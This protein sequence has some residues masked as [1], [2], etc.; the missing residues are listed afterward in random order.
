MF[1]MLVILYLLLGGAGSGVCAVSAVLSLLCPKDAVCIVRSRPA[2]RV[3]GAA[4]PSPCVGWVV[5]PP[6]QYRR[7]MAPLF[8]ASLA[9]ITLGLACLAFD[10]GR[11][12]RVLLLFAS[13]TL[14]HITVGSWA[15]VLTAVLSA[16]L[17]CAWNAVALCLPLT[18]VRVAEV[19]A[20][21]SSLVS[22]AYTGLLLQGI[23]A[24]PLWGSLWLPVL[25]VLS[26][27][28]CGF[29][30]TIATMQLTGSTRVFG[31]VAR[32]VMAG[33]TAIIAVESVAAVLFA[34]AVIQMAQSQPAA[35]PTEAVASFS[36]AE[37]I[38]GRDA[39]VF[40]GAFCV[41]GMAVPFV[42]EVAMLAAPRA[43]GGA[44]SPASLVVSLCV[45]IGGFAL[46]YG[47]VQA[48]AHPI[49]GLP[50]AG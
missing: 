39:W 2:S 15:L 10:A 38:A 13:P 45:L 18:F 23:D 50:F 30:V 29:A 7:L 9:S 46:R 21:L 31:F 24:V 20:L 3:R 6:W 40:W 11:I 5:R 16:V 17:L 36:A 1:G 8:A 44:S 34:L 12:D 19:L 49:V 4:V 22:M 26:S 43:R 48:G 37:L 25:F 27:L 41:V 42:T 32:R 14:T 35:S 47:V 33:D 28:S